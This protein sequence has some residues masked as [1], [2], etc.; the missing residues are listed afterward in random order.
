MNDYWEECIA[1]ALEETGLSATSEQIKSIACDVRIGHE[2]YGMAHGH[3]CIP[4]PLQEENSKLS[5]ALK[6]E[7]EKIQCPRCKGSG[8][9]IS[10]GGT[11]ES[12]S[13]CIKCS[14]EGKIHPKQV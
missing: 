10:Y 12:N 9:I 13:Q 11:F 3:D 2:N 14:G 7:R 4:N 6:I 5:R 8:R 1:N